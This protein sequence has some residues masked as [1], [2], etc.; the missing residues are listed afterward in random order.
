LYTVDSVSPIKIIT[1]VFS[2]DTVFI[3]YFRIFPAF[4]SSC[5]FKAA[6]SDPGT[7]FA[8]VPAIEFTGDISPLYQQRLL[9]EKVTAAQRRRNN[10]AR[11]AKMMDVVVAGRMAKMRVRV[12][13]PARNNAFSRTADTLTEAMRRSGEAEL[14][15]RPRSAYRDALKN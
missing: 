13:E 5:L 1:P 11:T 10:M 6:L 4:S 14:N 7:S 2:Q 15:T 9:S 3:A 8:L 12:T